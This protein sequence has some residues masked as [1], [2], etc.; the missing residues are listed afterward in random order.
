MR[1][2][3]I[4][5]ARR[6]AGEIAHDD[7]YARSSCL[8]ICDATLHETGASD[9]FAAVKEQFLDRDDHRSLRQTAAFC[10]IAQKS[11]GPQL[12]E[13]SSTFAARFGSGWKAC[14]KA[15]ETTENP[16]PAAR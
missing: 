6:R 4:A 8:S 1:S 15:A 3:E 5:S 9:R 14:Q 16:A 10:D 13:Q 7:A 12:S 2:S 11:P